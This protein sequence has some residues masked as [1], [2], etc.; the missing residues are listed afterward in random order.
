MSTL[1]LELERILPRLDLHT[2]SLVEGVL[3]NVIDLAKSAEDAGSPWAGVSKD[4]NGYP[5]GYFEATFG[6][7]GSDPLDRAE[8]GTLPNREEW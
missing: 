8:Q 7:F 5:Q 1:T 4:A 2:K 6:S 3:R